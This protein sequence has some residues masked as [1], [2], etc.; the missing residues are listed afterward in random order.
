MAVRKLY[1]TG[2]T[3]IPQTDWEQ[4]DETQRDFLKNKPTL[5]A[6]AAKDEIETADLASDF[7]TSLDA[8]RADI[9]DNADAIDAITN[10]LYLD[11]F[12]GVEEEIANL[13]SGEIEDL[14]LADI[15]IGVRVKTIEDDYLKD[16]HKVALDN[17][18][19]A[20]TTRAKEAEESLQGQI[21]TIV[22]NPDAEGVINSIKEFTK[23]I[24]DHGSIADGFKTDI[25][26]NT[27]AINEVKETY[28][29]QEQLF[30]GTK[31]EYDAAYAEGRIAV[32]AL[33][34]ILDDDDDVGVST[35]AILGQ[36]ILGQMILQ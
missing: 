34:I 23:Y 33:V 11:S 19:T 32:K 16:E 9:N 5:G 12:G 20:E 15:A 28:V 1:V 26:Q 27:A 35:S 21:N 24:E 13:K 25:E 30:V 7:Q 4:T 2:G 6:L 22:D 14:Q 29:K 36:A 8:M 31:A 17:K 3:I 10:G 18:I